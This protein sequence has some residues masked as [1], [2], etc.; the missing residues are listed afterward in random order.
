MFAAV[1]IRV[2]ENVISD[3]MTRITSKKKTE[4]YKS[5]SLTS[6]ELEQLTAYI[7]NG[8]HCE[9]PPLDQAASSDKFIVMGRRDV[10]NKLLA[11]YIVVSMVYFS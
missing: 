2:R 8:A 6:T 1:K 9:C 3:G 11:N 5:G 10:D 7:E 4:A